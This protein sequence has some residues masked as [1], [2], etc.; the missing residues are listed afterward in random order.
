MGTLAETRPRGAPT[1]RV[2]VRDWAKVGPVPKCP[3]WLV[4]LLNQHTQARTQTQNRPA[5][6]QY[7]FM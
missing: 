1:T 5:A 7:F 4:A 2:C 6:V 3:L